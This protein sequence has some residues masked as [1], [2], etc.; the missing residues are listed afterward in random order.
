[1]EQANGHVGR[2]NCYDFLIKHKSGKRHSDADSL[3]RATHADD[4]K[5]DPR[6]GDDLV[7]FGAA[8]QM[9]VPMAENNVNEDLMIRKIRNTGNV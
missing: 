5:D 9:E 4:P 1:M 7:V 3:S 6:D 2:Q 8:I